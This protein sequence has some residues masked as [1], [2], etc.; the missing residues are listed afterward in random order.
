MPKVLAETSKRRARGGKRKGGCIGGPLAGST[1][2]RASSSTMVSILTRASPVSTQA[3]FI[4]GKEKETI[5][6]R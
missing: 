3:R 4:W 6:S 2:A 5:G 1:C